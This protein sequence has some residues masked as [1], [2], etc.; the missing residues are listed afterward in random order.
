MRRFDETCGSTDMSAR[1]S[2]GPPASATS[3]SSPSSLT[4][5]KKKF[6]RFKQPLLPGGGG[7]PCPSIYGRLIPSTNPKCSRKFSG[8]AM[9]GLT[10][11]LH[12]RKTSL[13]GGMANHDFAS[14][15]PAGTEPSASGRCE[16]LNCQ[17]RVI[18]IRRIALA[19]YSPRYSIRSAVP[20]RNSCGKPSK[21]QVH[22]TQLRQAPAG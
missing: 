11:H 12:A 13:Q 4:Y 20:I 16:G 5:P 14:S 21:W 15:A 17:T 22:Q 18:P 10:Y 8:S 1:S 19:Q 7:P 3:T 6:T 9:S 2:I